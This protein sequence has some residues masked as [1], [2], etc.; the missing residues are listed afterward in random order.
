[1]SAERAVDVATINTIDDSNI[2]G[3]HAHS[4]AGTILN[5]TDQG[6]GESRSPQYDQGEGRESHQRLVASMDRYPPQSQSQL[7]SGSD[8][9]TIT[10]SDLAPAI[11]ATTTSV[12]A[13]PHTASEPPF[14][15]QIAELI[16]NNDT[17]NTNTN[18]Y[19]NKDAL[20]LEPIDVKHPIIHVDSPRSSLERE[21]GEI[22]HRALEPVMEGPKVSRCFTPLFLALIR[23]SEC[24]LA[25]Q[26]MMHLR[27]RMLSTS[28]S[29]A[30]HMIRSL[31]LF[32]LS[33]PQLLRNL[34]HL[35]VFTIRNR[36]SSTFGSFS[37]PVNHTHSLFHLRR[38]SDI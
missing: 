29:L 13:D 15:L 8:L 30:D 17:T 19:N 3:Q 6:Y 34:L 5:S 20:D 21:K 37:C 38:P 31:F 27:L 32:F 22:K 9:P 16:P 35:L 23:M 12:S 36:H 24:G 33:F 4:G 2:N 28:S 26:D 1:M 14:N 18:K 10:M 25:D 11:P 7:E